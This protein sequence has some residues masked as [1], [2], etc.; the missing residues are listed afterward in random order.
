MKLLTATTAG[1]GGRPSDFTWCTEGELVTPVAAICDRDMTEGPDG[2]CGC[3]RSWA[4][5]NSHRATTTA[6]VR[7]LEGFTLEDVT[8]AVRAYRE[9]S[10]W[11]AHTE[12]PDR[13]VAEEAAEIAETAAAYAAGTVLEIRLGDVAVRETPEVPRG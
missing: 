2:G 12:D 11:L 3:G 13:D 8:V 4:G 1:Q 10:G 6:M 7:D 9:Q 5:L